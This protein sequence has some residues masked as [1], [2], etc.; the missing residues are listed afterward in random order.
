MP[1]LLG[2]E[3][4]AA[5]SQP[6]SPTS[7]SSAC[8]P[9]RDRQDPLRPGGSALPR[10]PHVMPN[11]DSP[12]DPPAPSPV[13][14][15]SGRSGR[16]HP[17]CGS[18]RASSPFYPGCN[19]AGLVWAEE[20]PLQQREPSRFAFPSTCCCWNPFKGHAT[21]PCPHGPGTRRHGAGNRAAS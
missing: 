20:D 19:R 12:G 21:L 17:H 2:Q 5:G 9:H 7:H 6:S 1:V 18:A 14:Q 8:G 11:V 3:L 16:Q 10:T 15:H 4:Q 13:S